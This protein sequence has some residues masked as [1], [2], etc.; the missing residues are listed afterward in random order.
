MSL[1]KLSQ[2]YG[3]AGFC[4]RGLRLRGVYRYPRRDNQVRFY[5][6]E[7]P[8]RLLRPVRVNFDVRKSP[9]ADG[10]AFP[11]RCVRSS[12]AASAEETVFSRGTPAVVPSP[13]GIRPVG[14]CSGEMLSV[15]PQRRGR[16]TV[17]QSIICFR[18][19]SLGM[20]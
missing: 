19:L 8:A 13:R 10:N 9:G 2:A 5:A 16:P 15:R 17:S 1:P 4:V 14:P 20:P 7:N 12:R 3:R 11:C 6:R 18:C